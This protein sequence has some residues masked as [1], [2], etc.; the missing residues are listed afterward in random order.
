[1]H[2]Y[3]IKRILWLIPIIICVS[4]IV[5]MLI[6]LAPGTIID[7]MITDEMTQDEINILRSRYNLDK[8]MIYRYGIYMSK[9][10]RGDLGVSDINGLS[11]WDTY[12]ERLPNTLILAGASLF[13][14]AVCAIPMGIFAARHAGKTADN[15]TTTFSLLG[16]SMP[17]FWVALLLLL[18]FS[19]KL[20]WLPA[21]GN[22]MGIRSLILPA[23]SSS[24]GLMATAT[25]QTRSSMLEVLN[26]DY[27]RTARA[28]GVSEKTVIRKHALGNAWIPILT[29][30]GTSLAFSISGSAI[31]E[32]VFA[33]PGVGRM[34][35]EA[36][37]R[38]DVT[39]V[40]GTVILTTIFFVLV[41][42][43]VDMAYA[44]VDPRIRAQYSSGGKR[45]LKI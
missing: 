8:P 3:I 16:I 13:I 32:A 4:F 23:L 11:V 30:I 34:T 7:S 14:G 36:V 41:Q 24:F 45:R 12:I 18:L 26:S 39:T 5:F 17:N 40:C 29:T 15:I 20:G 19:L 33:W 2:R 38:R 43:L 9:L 25:R 22:R 27:L 21:G 1:M 6:D 35:V 10:V 37:G 31:T 42:L 28:K 44:F